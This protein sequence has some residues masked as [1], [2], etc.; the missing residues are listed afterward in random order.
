MMRLRAAIRAAAPDIVYCTTSAAFLCAP[1][2]RLAG[3]R[4]VIGHLQEI[5]TRSDRLALGQLA[6]ACT[7]LLAIS[8]AV[9]ASAGARLRPR[10]RV[11]VNGLG[12]PD[13]VTKVAERSG[14]LNFL[15]A[16]RWNAWKGHQTL[17]RAWDRAETDATL[18]V[19]GGPP[20]IGE[21]VDVRALT[22]GL[23]R[24]GSVRIIGEVDDIG[25]F[26]HDA[27]VVVVPSDSAEPFGLIAIEAFARGRPV[28]ASAAGGLLDIVS[29]GRDGWLFP[30]QDVEAL[31][32]QIER[33]E[34]AEVAAA[35]ECG[36]QKYVATYTRE[37][38]AERWRR[39]TG[40]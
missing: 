24:R 35:G 21:S 34:R 3:V 13:D 15:V 14:P 2:A 23:I 4:Q 19:V 22:Q 30:P 6:R 25:A 33:R 5:W 12:A 29:D 31:A 28:V 26:I 11:V 16:S 37:Q 7:R 9:A 10:I 40:V 8:D 18:T 39:A 1:T 20:P 36:R 32:H 27:D 17:L 38:F